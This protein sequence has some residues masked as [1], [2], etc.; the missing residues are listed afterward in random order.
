MDL[1]S[2]V[3]HGQ[4]VAGGVYDCL[5]A[6]IVADA[7]YD[8]LALSGAGIAAAAAGVPDLGLL[9][10]GELLH[11]TRNVIAAN[12][13]PVIVDADTGFGNELNVMRTC[14]LLG[15]AGAAAVMLEDQV[16]PKRCGHLDGKAVLPAGQFA[17]VIR[18][19]RRSL[20][21]LDVLVIARTDALAVEGLDAAVDRSL[22][23]LDAG[24]D[25][26]FVEA[27][28]TMLDVEAIADRV[29]G[30][31]MFS[32]ATGGRSPSVHLDVL[33]DLGFGLVVIPG[34][35]LMPAIRGMR[36]AARAV[37]HQRG[38]APLAAYDVP[39]RAIFESVGLAAWLQRAEEFATRPMADG[40]E[41]QEVVG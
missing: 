29:P 34:L 26:T 37:L 40:N 18:A 17:S 5:S 23:A 30:A 6:A 28:T 7:G 12:D 11:T 24:A 35:S 19:A 14:E 16:A 20:D 8:A 10:F 9:S 31:K 22:R 39:P 13:R 21:G 15:A 38:D 32:L 1:R 36:D 25:I 27:P 33:N 4:V 3:A 41:S 2:A